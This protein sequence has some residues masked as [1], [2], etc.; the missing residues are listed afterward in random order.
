MIFEFIKPTSEDYEI[1]Y[2]SEPEEV[3]GLMSKFLM[4]TI[5]FFRSY[6]DPTVKKKLK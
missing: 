2:I 6:R 3:D 5:V 1:F 4:A